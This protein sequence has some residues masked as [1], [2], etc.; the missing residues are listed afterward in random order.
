MSNRLPL[1]TRPAELI[2]FL[3]V[4]SSEIIRLTKDVGHISNFSYPYEYHLTI[5]WFTDENPDQLRKWGNH[6]VDF[7]KDK[8]ARLEPED[9]HSGNPLFSIIIDSAGRQPDVRGGGFYFQPNAQST[10]QALI[11]HKEITSLLTTNQIC[12]SE[13]IFDYNPHI[14]FTPQITR[15]ILSEHQGNSVL[16]RINDKIAGQKGGVA[17]KVMLKPVAV[18]AILKYPD[19]LGNEQ[20][21]TWDCKV[22]QPESS[23]LLKREGYRRNPRRF[24]MLE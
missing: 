7:L 20:K 19:K 8:I 1:C 18:R 2:V 16:E 6:A 22:E 12:S 23:S 13:F 9:L 15:E 17:R 11:L 24:E 4:D 5:G 21:E 14:T 3:E 10:Q